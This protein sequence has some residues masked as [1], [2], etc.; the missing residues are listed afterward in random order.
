MDAENDE[1]MEY[2]NMLYIHVPPVQQQSGIVDCGVFVI[3][4]AVHA[5]LGENVG[6]IEFQQEEMRSHLSKCLWKKTFSPFPKLG[7]RGHRDNYFLC[8]ILELYCN[9]LMPETYG[10]MVECE[11]CFNW[12]HQDC[13]DYDNI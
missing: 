9:C 7:E 5:A 11:H 13:V 6:E 10:N 12:F 8:W 3:A 4:F 1:T 2:R